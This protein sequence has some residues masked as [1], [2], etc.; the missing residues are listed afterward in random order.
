[1]IRTEI[2]HVIVQDKHFD[3]TVDSY[4][5]RDDAIRAARDYLTSVAESDWEEWTGNPK[6][7]AFFAYYGGNENTVRVI[8]GHL[9]PP[10][11][12]EVDHVA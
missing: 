8:D 2:W 7:F 3:V 4:V 1:M 6:A 12:Q 5:D 10:K 11:G 9:Y